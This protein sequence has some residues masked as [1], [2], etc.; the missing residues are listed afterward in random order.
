MRSRSTGCTVWRDD[1][2]RRVAPRDL[3]QCRRI[4]QAVGEILDLIG[5]RRREQQVLPLP[6]QEGENPLDVADEAHVEHPVGFV[7]DED[8][9]PR[10]IEVALALVVEQAAGRGDEDVD[11]ALQLR[12]LRADA[13]AA[14]HD[15]R[16]LLRVL[17]VHANAFLDLR[18]E[19]ARGREDQRADRLFRGSRRVRGCRGRRSEPLQHRQHEAGGLA[20]AG[21]R[22]G[23]QIAAGEH[24]GDRLQLNRGGLRVAVF[25][26]GAHER[27][28][29]AERGKGHDDFRKTIGLS[30]LEGASRRQT[31]G[32]GASELTAAGGLDE[33]PRERII[34]GPVRPNRRERPPRW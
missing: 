14:E 12:G 5:K 22:A 25:G 9:D 27:V 32:G 33:L 28:G 19:L 3:D 15:H 4:E 26:H 34:A 20:G 8:L 31:R 7:E 1:F 10:Q 16:R 18:R 13:D 11:A 29:Q 23:E 17:A 6:G 30:P 21:L 2:D 24:R